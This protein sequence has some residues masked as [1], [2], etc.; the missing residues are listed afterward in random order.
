MGIQG[1][2]LRLFIQSENRRY[3][4]RLPLLCS[5]GKGVTGHHKNGLL[6]INLPKSRIFRVTENPMEVCKMDCHEQVGRYQVPSGD[7]GKMVDVKCAYCGGRGK[8]PFG[9]P[10]PESN[11]S[12]CGGKGYNRVVPPYEPCPACNG[13]GRLLGR[14]LNCTTCKGKGVVT[15]RR[16]LA[17]RRYGA[18]AIAEPALPKDGPIP[19]SEQALPWEIDRPSSASHLSVAPSVHE[20]IS[21]ADQVAT[22]I[23]SFPGV[24]IED[25]QAVFGLSKE[26]AQEML[27]RL[28]K[29]HRIR[30]KEDGLYHPA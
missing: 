5:V 9:V 22:C 16:P 18:R 7:P 24:K 20:T 1:H 8:D 28:V 17:E 3:I 4:K 14:R 11:C 13:T 27:Q 29:T 30:R 12:T 6:E 25:V 15:V 26:D 21:L 19:G 23:T 10:G 2:I